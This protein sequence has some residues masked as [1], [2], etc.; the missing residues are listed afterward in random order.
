MADC[1]SIWK[2]GS[3]IDYYSITPTVSGSVTIRLESTE[4]TYLLLYEGSLTTGAPS[5]ENDDHGTGT[6]SQIVVNMTAGTKYIIGAT[7]NVSNT[8]GSYTLSLTMPAVPTVPQPTTPTTTPGGPTIPAGGPSVNA[9]SDQTVARG[10]SVSLTGTGSPANDDDDASYSWTQRD[11]NTV[12]LKN[13]ITNLPYTSGLHGS[14]AKFTAPSTTGTLIFRL[15]VTDAGTGLSS[16]DE[17][18]IIVQ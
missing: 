7:T 11:S 18:V 6:N 4:N 1:E 10:A 3:Y 2:T 9:G 13:S 14:S 5:Q 12:S 17:L 8:T 16:W 15:T